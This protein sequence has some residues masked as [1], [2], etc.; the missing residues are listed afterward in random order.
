MSRRTARDYAYKL[1]FQSLFHATDDADES[2]A[3]SMYADPSLSDEDKA[4]MRDVVGGVSA[5]EEELKA[6]IVSTGEFSKLIYKFR[7]MD[8]GTLLRNA[9]TQETDNGY[10]RYDIAGVQLW[11]TGK[12]N[13]VDYGVGGT[14]KF[15]GYAKGY[16][17]D[18]NA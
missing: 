16:G 12:D 5:H 6:V 3:A 10:R 7:V 4:Y 9:R 2:E 18:G 1:I 14:Y 11:E 15:T 17:T 13:A 8:D